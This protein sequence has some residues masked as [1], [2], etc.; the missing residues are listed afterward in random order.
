MNKVTFP[1]ADK[2]GLLS[3]GWNSF[4][5]SSGAR[6]GPRERCQWPEEM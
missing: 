2:P 6:Y 1:K 5:Y 4:G 3:T